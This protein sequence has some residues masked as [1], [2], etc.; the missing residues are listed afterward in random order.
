M[1]LSRR[2]IFVTGKGGVGKTTVALALGLAGAHAGKRTIV[3]DINGEGDPREVEL[4]PGLSR[5]S[6]DPQSAMEEYLT[7]KVPGPAAAALRQSRLFQT[8]AMATPGMRE[9]LCMGK[10]WELAQFER[11]TPGA[12]A[13]D[14]VIVD[15]PASGHGAALLRTP[16]TFA[17]IARV[18]PIA[19]QARTIADTIADPSFTAVVAVCTPEEMP[20]NETF[21]LRDTLAA[22]PE[23]QS[24]DLVILNGRYPDRFTE[25]D[26][27]VLA[28]ALESDPAPDASSAT[29]AALEVALAEHQRA[30]LHSEQE[31]RLRAEFGDRL[32]VLP[33]L[34]EASVELPQIELLA[35]ELAS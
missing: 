23:P 24:L 14:L 1:L 21:E 33:F 35:R 13:Y 31:Q 4:A 22:P 25:P 10:L 28:G 12:D 16:R 2:L 5:I 32:R 8:F 9:L 27:A 3:A 30:G 7:V 18:G 19:H 29:R 20:V 26:A 11:R 15:A 17:E 6:V 34:F